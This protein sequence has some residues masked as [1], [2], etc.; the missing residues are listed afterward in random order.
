[1]KIATDIRTL[2]SRALFFLFL[3]VSWGTSALAQAP[4]AKKEP[5]ATKPVAATAKAEPVRTAE[6][7][8]E[9]PGSRQEGIKVHGH[10]VVEVRNPDGSLVTHKEFENS[11]QDG[12][13]TLLLNLLTRQ[14][15]PGRW[16]IVVFDGLCPPVLLSTACQI[17]E[18]ASGVTPT[19]S[20]FTN[21]NVSP[22]V[23]TLPLT[24]ITLSGSLTASSGGSVSSVSLQIGNCAGSIAPQSC[25]VSADSG[26]VTV[27]SLTAFSSRQLGAPVPVLQGQIVQVTVTISLS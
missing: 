9:P 2:A 25:T 1:M 22:S 24:Q 7:A 13:K 27:T 3:A 4:A 12:G 6:P 23:A 5:A 10:W 14:A 19:G 18:S 17:F 20:R 16:S 8:A 15:T 26:I 11:L 21:L